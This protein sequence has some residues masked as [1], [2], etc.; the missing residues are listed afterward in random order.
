MSSP[1]LSDLPHNAAKSHAN[2]M[3]TMPHF[4]YHVSD[5]PIRQLRKL[6]L[7]DV[8]REASARVKQLRAELSQA[9]ELGAD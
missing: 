6:E 1:L 3:V 8:Y 2:N 9:P 7:Y 5:F 4:N